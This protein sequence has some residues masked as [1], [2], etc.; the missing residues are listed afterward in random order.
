[1]PTSS[2]TPTL[3][4]TDTPPPTE[5]PATPTPEPIVTPAE[6]P[7]P[8][9]QR[10]QTEEFEIWLPGT[11]E[12]FP[13]EREALEMMVDLWEGINP[14]LAEYMDFLI[15][16]G[17][18]EQ[19]IDFWA[20]DTEATQF[21]TNV[22]ILSMPMPI[23]P[24]LYVSSASGEMERMGATIISTD[25][26]LEIGGFSTG[27][28]EYSMPMEIPGWDP[29]VARGVQYA[30]S[31]GSNTYVLTFSTSEDQISGMASIFEMSANSFRVY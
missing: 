12:S 10:H 28:I 11:W 15:Q 21:V 3:A 8:G 18:Y 1:M 22:N 5:P 19:Q 17:M 4:P 27:R 31:V 2:S 29:I 26:S 16:S 7:A 9:W 25:D 6:A 30:L 13:V 24:A 20:M 14:R 23:S